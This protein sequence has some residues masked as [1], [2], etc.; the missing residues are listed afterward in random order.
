MQALAH[1]LLVALVVDLEQTGQRL[2]VV[3]FADGEAYFLRRLV[4]AV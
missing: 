2:A 4:K 3:G 1:F